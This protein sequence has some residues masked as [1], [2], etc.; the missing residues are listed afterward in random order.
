MCGRYSLITNISELEERFGF[1]SDGIAYAPGFNIAPT[2]M[3]LTVVNE[4][5]NQARYMRWGLIPS[6]AKDISIGS[7]MINARA[8]T[9]AEK[10]SFRTALRRRRCLILADGFY[11]WKRVGSSKRPMRVV[12]KS[13]EPFAFAGLWETWR[14]S[15]GDDITSCTIITTT[16]N[17]LMEPIHNR[18]PVILPRD[19]EDFWLDPA[20]QDSAALSDVLAS[21]PADQMEAYEVSALVN[22]VSNN[23]PEVLE[24]VAQAHFRDAL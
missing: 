15:S 14:P 23:T 1:T 10:P 22:S 21:Y 16:P 5:G 18:M 17:D 2:Q 24:R 11:E 19:A 7:R 9:I 8:E 12:M 13:G 3:V 4:G 20:V 6:W